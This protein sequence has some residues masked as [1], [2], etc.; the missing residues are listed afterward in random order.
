MSLLVVAAGVFGVVSCSKDGGSTASSGGVVG[1]W[2]GSEV[3]LIFNSDNTGVAIEN[4]SYSYYENKTHLFTYTM[5]DANSGV[6]KLQDED[7]DDYYDDDEMTVTFKI[8]DGNTMILYGSYS[9]DYGYTWVIDILTRKGGTPSGGSSTAN[10]VGTWSGTRGSSRTLTITCNANGTGNY[11]YARVDYY[12][13]NETETGTFTYAMT[14]AQNGYFYIQDYYYGTEALR[15][16]VTGNT[17][18]LYE[19]NEVEWVLTKH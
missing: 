5:T 8:S 6:I 15:F 11:V 13:G 2:E 7:Y 4:G 19:D 12:S 16:S 3:T 9:Y 1:T 17:M 10:V 14:D 18:Y